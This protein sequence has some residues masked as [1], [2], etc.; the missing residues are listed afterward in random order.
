MRVTVT[1]SPGARAKAAF[2]E[3]EYSALPQIANSEAIISIDGT[4]T[5]SPAPTF[6]TSD[7]APY[8]GH[9]P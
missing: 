7:P 4:I 8:R 5:G 6:A 1:M 3:A 9:A 2:R